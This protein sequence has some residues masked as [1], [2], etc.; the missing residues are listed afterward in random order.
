MGGGM[1]HFT[2]AEIAQFPPHIRAQIERK[3]SSQP[4]RSPISDETPQ[5]TIKLQSDQPVSKYRNEKCVI[6]GVTFDS[7]REGKRYLRLKAMQLCGSISGLELQ[8]EY[9]IEI[10]GILIC[11]YFADFRYTWVETGETII[12]DVKGV[13]TNVFALKKKLAEALHGIQIVEVK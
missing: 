4:R 6:D 8:P 2:E 7:K 12:E 9:V 3:L 13:R 1:S 5:P 11:S 10:N